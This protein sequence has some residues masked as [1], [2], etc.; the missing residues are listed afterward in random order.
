MT[1]M[2]AKLVKLE[3]RVP[4]SWVA[5]A[6]LITTTL[7]NFLRPIILTSRG[8]FSAARN[9]HFGWDYIRSTTATSVLII[10]VLPIAL[11]HYGKV[12]YRLFSYLVL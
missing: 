3:R 2:N 8:L 4:L 12:L 5:H 10:L 7:V 1:E 11:E 6:I 9:R